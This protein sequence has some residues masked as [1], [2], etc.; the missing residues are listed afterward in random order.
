M[1]QALTPVLILTERFCAPPP[2]QNQEQV[3]EG[4]KL[5]IKCFAWGH[6]VHHILPKG[7]WVFLLNG[8]TRARCSY[9]ISKYPSILQERK[10][11]ISFSF[12]LKDGLSALHKIYTTLEN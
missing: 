6:F 9:L 3:Q 1:F 7:F 4:L 11:F 8:N 12:F 2:V 10:S 5:Q